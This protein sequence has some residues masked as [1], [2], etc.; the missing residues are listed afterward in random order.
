[1]PS[2]LPLAANYNNLENSDVFISDTIWQSELKTSTDTTI[3]VPTAS[4]LGG[5][6]TASV[7]YMVARIRHTPNNDVWFAVNATA[8]I[9]SSTTPVLGVSELL[10]N[11]VCDYKVK[12]G[13]VLH[14]ISAASAA[15]ISVAFY[16]QT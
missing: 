11:N 4:D 1:M 12:S 3:T 10:D 16:W 9:P 14:F 7:N 5:T 2:K 6:N 8:V 13:D 15:Y